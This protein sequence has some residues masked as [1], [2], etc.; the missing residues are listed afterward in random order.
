VDE[1]DEVRQRFFSLASFPC[2]SRLVGLTMNGPVIASPFSWAQ[3]TGDHH[4]LATLFSP[5]L[6]SSASRRR[7]HRGAGC[8]DRRARGVH[9]RGGG[10]SRSAT[11]RGILDGRYDEAFRGRVC[12]GRSHCGASRVGGAAGEVDAAAAQFDEEED[13]EPSERDRLDGEEVDS[14][15]ALCLLAE[16]RRPRRRRRRPPS[17]SESRRSV[18][19][20]RP[21]S[22]RGRPS[23][24]AA[25]YDLQVAAVALRFARPTATPCGSRWCPRRSPEAC[26]RLEPSAGSTRARTPRR[27]RGRRGGR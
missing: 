27:A 24:D 7:R 17:R 9:A 23:L 19:R 18:P 3:G 26:S 16:K 4:G 22:R 6:L 11:S 1:V 15:H 13:V 14:E 10:D 25:T 2:L 20:L 5:E 21:S 8:S 12:L